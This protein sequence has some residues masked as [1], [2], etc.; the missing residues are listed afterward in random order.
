MSAK[1]DNRK[2]KK[3]IADNI[4]CTIATATHN[5]EPWVSPVYFNYSKKTYT[6]YWVSG[7]N[8]RHSQL[9]KE[10][11]RVAIVIFDSSAPEGAGDG[12]Y[13]I[14][15]AYEVPENELKEAT[16]EFYG[17][18]HPIVSKDKPHVPEEFKNDSPRRIYKAVIKKIYKLTDGLYINGQY[19]DK[20][21]EVFL[22]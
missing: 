15:R 1:E 12:V 20:K 2:A 13:L 14:A 4:Y 21:V 8:A 10:N 3:I 5:G 7:K 6:I 22:S 9:I 17:G 18:R 16:Q 11:N 19:V